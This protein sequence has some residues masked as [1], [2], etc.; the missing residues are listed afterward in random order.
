[1]DI[2]NMTK[3]EIK[4][5]TEKITNNTSTQEEELALLKFLNKEV[6]EISTFIR[7]VANKE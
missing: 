6:N 5:I 4:S 1:M 2:Q 7:E 3:E